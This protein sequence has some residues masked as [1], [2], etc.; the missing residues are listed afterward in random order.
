MSK[1]EMRLIW[2]VCEGRRLYTWGEGYMNGEK[3]I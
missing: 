3:V 2:E 1:Q